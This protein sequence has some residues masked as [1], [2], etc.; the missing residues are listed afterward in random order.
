MDCFFSILIP[1]YNMSGKMNRCID[2]IKNQTFGDFEGIIVD[3]GSKDGTYE[4]IEAIAKE[5]G[6]FKPLHHSENKSLLAARYTAMRA[7]R[8]EYILFLDSD[9]YIESDTLQDLKAF[10]EKNPVDVVRFGYRTEPE[11]KD[12]LPIHTD[13]PIEC[14]MSGRTTPAIWKNCYRKAVVDKLLERT[15]P[16]YCNMGED[17]YLCGVLFSCADSFGNIDRV[18][19]H[20]VTTEGMSNSIS[21]ISIEKI[22]RDMKSVTASGTNLIRFIEQYNPEKLSMTKTAVKNMYRYVLTQNTAKEPD[23]RNIVDRL[24]IF[25]TEELRPIYEWGCRYLLPFIIER[26][27]N[28]GHE[29]MDDIRAKYIEMIEAD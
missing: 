9:D 18:Y 27:I 21:D 25:N 5:D 22:Q 14:Y 11:G 13:D 29:T 12:F 8:G 19:H 10:L 4:E 23:F 6:R 26:H 2:S 7:A 3:D 20:Y 1:A 16:F 17:V 24:S 28:K 15:E